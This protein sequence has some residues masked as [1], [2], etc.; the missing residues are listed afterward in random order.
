MLDS[1]PDRLDSTVFLTHLESGLRDHYDVKLP[2]HLMLSKL[3]SS[4]GDAVLQQ[5]ER[6][7]EPLEKT[8]TARLKGDSVKQEVGPARFQL[9]LFSF[10][11]CM[12]VCKCG[13]H[14]TGCHFRVCMA[15]WKLWCN[16]WCC[17]TESNQL[18]PCG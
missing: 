12:H 6:L 13:W 10:L 15:A 8:L 17:E 7:V 16:L 4:S 5:L 3:A 14:I 1:T 2:A 9:A 18:E 11:K